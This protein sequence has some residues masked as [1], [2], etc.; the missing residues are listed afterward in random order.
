VDWLFLCIAWRLENPLRGRSRLPLLRQIIELYCSLLSRMSLA[1]S[2]GPYFRV[3]IG[4]KPLTGNDGLTSSFRDDRSH[5][6]S[7]HFLYSCV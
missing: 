6:S 2:V 4:R 5:E 7:S 3:I 1:Q